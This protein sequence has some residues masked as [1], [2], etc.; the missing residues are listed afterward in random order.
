MEIKWLNAT[1]Q[2]F[3]AKDYLLPNQTVQERLK[4][5]GDTAEF[6]LRRDLKSQELSYK[7]DGFSE[8]LQQY[9]ANGWISLS[10]PIWI[11]FGNSR[12]YPISCFGSFADDSIESILSNISEIGT[13]T[14]VG[15]GTSVYLGE[16][17]GRGS[18]ITDN[19]VSNGSFSFLE[20]FQSTTNTIS[21]GCYDEETEILTEKG[22]ML[23]S[24][25]EKCWK[26]VRVAQVTECEKIEFVYSSQFFKY[27][28][29]EN[30]LH[31]KDSKNINLLVTKNH[32]MVYKQEKKKIIK[33]EDGSKKYLREIRD[34]FFSKQAETCPLH[35][36]VKFLHSGY[37]KDNDA[38]LSPIDRLKIAFQADGYA[39]AKY[40]N[41]IKFRFAKKRKAERLERLLKGANIS[42]KYSYY[43]KD[44]TYNYYFTTET[45]WEKTFSW[46]NIVDKSYKWAV[47]F[48]EE[49]SEWDSNKTSTNVS[50][51][52]IIKENVDVVQLVAS[53]AG[54]K[55]KIS[56]N[57]RENDSTRQ[58]IYTAT[59]SKG[60]YFGVEKIKPEE[61]YY[62]GF[63]YCAEVP[64]H[65]LIVR[66]GG[67]TLICGNSSR[68]G[69]MA[70]YQDITH[71]DIEE[72]LNIR[73]E[74]NPI[75]Q[76]TW[77][78]C[79]PSWWLQ[80]MKDGDEDKRKVWAKVIQKRFETGL[81]YIFF[82]DNANNNNSVPEVY[83]GDN[84][85]KA[86]NLCSEI[87]LPS[88]SE[89]SFVCD[90]S[91]LNDLYFE[92]WKD[93]DCVEVITFL[94]DAVMTEFI[95]KASKTKYMERS[96]AFATN[97]RAIG[98][99][100]L[101]YHSL[102]QSTMTP[103]ESLV[104]RNIN[105]TI[106]K[107]IQYKSLEASKLLG[108]MYGECKWT[109]GTKRRNT[110]TQAVAP[111]TSCVTPETEFLD[112]NNLPINFYTLFER[113]GLNLNNYLSI[114]VE[115]ENGETISLKYEDLVEIQRNNSLCTIK[116]KNLQ[117]N[118]KIINIRTNEI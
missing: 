65:R 111:T 83:R 101:G 66:R 89:E 77:G 97:H 103:F 86:S 113:G 1:S 35:R 88:N 30:L 24:E 68:R 75:Q 108:T 107:T 64:L 92:E 116:A 85:I 96:V 16:L 115:M 53:C 21:Q 87:F 48:L 80:E 74:G 38:G 81:P 7:L 40:P 67:H 47:E 94:L 52:S 50:Y 32:T 14:K 6:I 105:I 70:A 104:A 18:K 76:I 58:P 9:I 84:L 26:D 36:D 43:E 44:S 79:V 69:Y 33:Q 2:Q 51:S 20:L 112:G 31:F 72:W 93:T 11:N 62:E 25:L 71:P 28:V 41:Y 17:R 98:I 109:K 82:N 39:N 78:V 8:K 118:D 110:T 3:L 45:K 55:S 99:G 114:D 37:L 63:V 60:N 42:Y 61:V 19:G 5:I 73:S 29:A 54:Y 56:L 46:V 23:F 22:W 34:L 90:L 117:T 100:R 13:M 27:E 12:G 49:L 102:L 4:I 95:E 106:Q 59:I 15:G 91:S 57:L 10:T